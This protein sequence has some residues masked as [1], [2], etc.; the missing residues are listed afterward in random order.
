[1]LE[2]EE[3]A[4]PGFW[5]DLQG[6]LGVHLPKGHRGGGF[7]LPEPAAVIEERG[8]AV[9]PGPVLPTV[10]ESAV[11]SAKR[12]EQLRARRL[13]PRLAAGTAV[14]AVGLGR[15]TGP[16]LTGDGK[17]DRTL[18]GG[19]GIVPGGAL[20]D[21]VLVAV[22]DD[23]LAVSPDA[24][25]VTVERPPSPDRSRWSA[26]FR[27]DGVCIA[28]EALADARGDAVA[29]F[30][31]L[32]AA[33]ST[34]GA[35]ECV[36]VA[37]AYARVRE[38]FGRR[39]G[40]FQAVKHHLADMLVAT[41]RHHGQRTGEPAGGV[42]GMSTEQNLRTLRT[43]HHRVSA[44][45]V[46]VDRHA[47][48]GIALRLLNLR[49]A[50]RAV[51]GGPGLEGDITKLAGPK[52]GQRTAELLAESADGD[53]AF[54]DGFGGVAATSLLGTHVLTTAD[55]T[56]EISRDQIAGRVLGLPRAPLISR[57]D[58]TNH[59]PLNKGNQC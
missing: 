19:S 36:E 5:K 21:H 51:G 9:T 54:T 15:G 4:L 47:A 11:V 23:L 39:T 33:E 10:L 57:T 26:R 1:M 48:E 44:A 29:V 8:R 56:F 35:R 24:P 12:S 37:T 31:T 50:V 7:G 25:G 13:L 38:Q 18:T 46:R 32:V 52:D 14:R 40:T 34:G 53:L 3:E 43:V 27:L 41:E 22:G 16:A 59:S 6:L 30:R 55:G 45:K 58:G 28:A 42:G 2:A 49:R 20:T 17:G